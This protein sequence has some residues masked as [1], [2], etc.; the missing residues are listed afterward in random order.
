MFSK[1]MVDFDLFQPD[2]LE[3]ALR[4]LEK[5]GA[6]A[7]VMLG[8][9]DLVP[10]MKARILNPRVVINLSG[11]EALKKISFSEEEGLCFGAAVSLRELENYPVV[12]ARYPALYEG[13]HA[14]ASTQI[15]NIGT[16]VG[17]ICNA[18]PSADSAPALLVLHAKVH[19]LSPRGR[20][21]VPIEEFFTGVCRTVAAPDEIVT[22]VRIPTPAAGSRSIYYAHTVRRALDLAIVG[23]AVNLE[24]EKDVCREAAIALGTVAITPKRAGLAEALLQGKSLTPELMGEAARIAAEQECAPIS[25]MRASKEYRREM[26]RV[27]TENALK[28]CWNEEKGE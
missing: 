20:R 22:E 10:K 3:E 12:K 16:V 11:I 17:N 23:V 4:L 15:R 21:T 13:V 25:D 19:L 27:L 1:T 6:E 24:K 18:V 5:Y 9:T 2:T 28:H 8:G 7:K 14:I 26:V